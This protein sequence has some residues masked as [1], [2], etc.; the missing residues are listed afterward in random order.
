[1]TG[2]IV[3]IPYFYYKERL[4]TTPRTDPA[5]RP[6]SLSQTF[7][8]HACAFSPRSMCR[9]VLERSQHGASPLSVRAFAASPQPDTHTH[10]PQRCRARAPSPVSPSAR[11]LALL[12]LEVTR[13]S[14][15]LIMVPRPSGCA[16]SQPLISLTHTHRDT[17]CAGPVRNSR[18][19]TSPHHS[20]RSSHRCVDILARVP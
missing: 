2:H 15:D 1:M 13:S 12:S 6:R 7:P 3:L 20:V 4:S 14:K 10:I 9:A 19:R 16:H 5:R 8:R 18:T 11:L 17:R